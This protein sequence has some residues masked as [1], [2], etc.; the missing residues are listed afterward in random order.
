MLE[1]SWVT[2]GCHVRKIVEA[3]LPKGGSKGGATG[4]WPPP[5]GQD[6]KA[7]MATFLPA[8][9]ASSIRGPPQSKILEPPIELTRKQK[10]EVVTLD[11]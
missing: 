11:L 8:S 5:I 7:N 1:L 2:S 10:N 4:P 9:R 6:F 3:E